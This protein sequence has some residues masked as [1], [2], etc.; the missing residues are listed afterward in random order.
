MAIIKC[1]GGV[2]G[3][4]GN[5][6][7][8]IFSANKNGAYA[9]SWANI[10]NQ[11]SYAQTVNRFYW[12][13]ILPAWSEIDLETKQD[14]KDYGT[15]HP[16]QNPLGEWYKLTSLQWFTKCN[17]RLTTWGGSPV[18]TPPADPAP[19]TI[20]PN[21]FTYH[22]DGVAQLTQIDFTEGAWAGYWMIIDAMT[23]PHGQ[24]MSWTAQYYRMRADYEPYGDYWSFTLPHNNKFGVP[25]DGWQCM[26]RVFTGDNQGLISPAWEASAVYAHL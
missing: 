11:R 16:Q 2:V 4:R 5:L 12:S 13:Y 1:G 19:A 18:T 26:V 17:M 14:W 25:Q 20:S 22:D 8:N 10:T 3:I 6:G 7:G 23:I 9:R 24:A 21:S 15:A